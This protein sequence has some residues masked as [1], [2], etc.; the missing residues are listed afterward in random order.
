MIIELDIT[1]IVYSN[2]VG[3]WC[4]LPYPGHPKGC[5]NHG[6]KT[7]CPPGAPNIEDY[8]DFRK[9]LFM[10]IHE[11]DLATYAAKMKAKHPKWSDRQCRCVL[12]WQNGS[13]KR[14]KDEAGRLM[15]ENRLN[16][17]TLCPEGMGMNV[18]ATAALHGVHLERTRNI[19]VCRHVAIVGAKAG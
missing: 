10:V 5:P 9:P 2:K 8:F 12:Y 7:G 3:E 14:L 6:I 1:Q 4:Q 11:F 18:F 16:T 19:S 13:R 15:V 17:I